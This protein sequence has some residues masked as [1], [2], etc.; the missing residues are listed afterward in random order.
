[1]VLMTICSSAQTCKRRINKYQTA[2]DTKRCQQSLEVKDGDLVFFHDAAGEGDGAAFS[3]GVVLVAVEVHVLG[4]VSVGHT[5]AAA[6][7]RT[8]TVE[9]MLL[10]CVWSYRHFV[11]AA[12]GLLLIK[13]NDTPAQ[14]AWHEVCIWTKSLPLS[15]QSR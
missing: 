13:Q 4:P 12:T 5:T 15:D 1:M 9:D 11:N 3:A 2:N 7:L 6:K 8:H 10:I 14:R